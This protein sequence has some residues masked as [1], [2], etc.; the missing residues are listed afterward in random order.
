MIGL[1]INT[2]VMRSDLSGDPSFRELLARRPQDGDRGVR[3]SGV[4]VRAAGQ[5]IAAA[6]R[7]V[8]AAAGAGAVQLPSADQRPAASN[9][10]RNW[11]SASRPTICRLGSRGGF[12]SDAR[13]V[14]DAAQGFH[15]QFGYD[16]QPVRRARRSHAWPATSR[17]CWKPSP[18]IPI[19][20]SRNCRLLTEGERQQVLVEWNQTEVDFPD[21]AACTS[22]SRPRCNARPEAVALVVRRPDHDLPPTERPGQ[23]LAHYLQR[24]GVGPGGA[25]G[26]LPGAVRWN[27]PWLSWRC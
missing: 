14:D 20:A 1:F 19:S 3:P 16:C 22:C 7:S 13:S 10:G 26:H 6:A 21:R 27:W 12:R 23:P 15:C 17:R 18:P 2:L 8:Q 4:A 25:G 9:A 11:R 5:G 24:R